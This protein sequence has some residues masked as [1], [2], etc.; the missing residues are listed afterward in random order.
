MY[1][2]KPSAAQRRAFAEK[3]K[4]PAEQAAYEAKQQARAEKRRE[5]SQHDYTTAGGRYVPTDQQYRYAMANMAEFDE[6]TKQSAN[7]VISAFV[8]NQVVHHDHIH[9]INEHMRSNY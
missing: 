4:D 2:W 9:A 6:T 8:C 7:L 5:T 1:K 3:M